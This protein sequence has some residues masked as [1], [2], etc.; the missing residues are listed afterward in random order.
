MGYS[1]SQFLADASPASLTSTSIQGINRTQLRSDLTAYANSLTSYIQNNYPTA[2]VSDIIGG[3]V[4]VP[5]PLANGQTLRQT[6]NPNQS[7]TPTDW[8]AIPSQYDATISITIPGATAQA[9]NSSDIY[10]HRLSIFFSSAF[11]PTLYL[12]GTAVTSGSASS[13]GTQVGIQFAITIPWATFASSTHL[14]TS[15]HRP[16]RVAAAADM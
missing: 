16:I 7:N 3:G 15:A 11:V 14:S 10:G 13:Q 1:R 12:D 5:T 2:G 4:I 9:Y 8:T 6:S